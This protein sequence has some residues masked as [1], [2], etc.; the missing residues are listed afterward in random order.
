MERSDRIKHPTGFVL[1]T[2]PPCRHGYPAMLGK[3]K[4]RTPGR[5]APPSVAGPEV[6]KA[7]EGY[8]GSRRLYETSGSIPHQSL[9]Q[10]SARQRGSSQGIQLA[11]FAPCRVCIVI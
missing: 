7:E 5:R 9:Q 4:G 1:P 6:H 10:H 8:K 2:G 11:N 3:D